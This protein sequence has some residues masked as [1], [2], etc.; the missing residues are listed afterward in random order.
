MS[1]STPA[2]VRF[3]ADC[4]RIGASAETWPRAVEQV[5]EVFVSV[6]ATTQGYTDRMIRAI[7]TF[8]PYVVVAPGLALVHARPDTDVHQ[9]TV[10][11]MTFPEGV[12]FGHPENDPVRVV[13]GIAVTRPEDHVKV[14]AAIARTADAVGSIEP[15]LA[16]KTP[17]ALARHVIEEV[18]PLVVIDASGVPVDT[19]T[20]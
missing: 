13:V 12:A 19:A 14:V 17:E 5:G 11:F 20:L 15:L 6:G 3:G 2:T 18:Q 9:N 8:G 16:A 1:P 10:V 4:V 7:K